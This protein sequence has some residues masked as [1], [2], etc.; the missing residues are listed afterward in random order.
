MKRESHAFGCRRNNPSTQTGDDNASSWDRGLS[1]G[2]GRWHGAVSSLPKT[3]CRYVMTALPH[4]SASGSGRSSSA[5][6][7]DSP[8]IHAAATLTERTVVP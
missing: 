5:A 8:A 2:A 6:R 4:Q 7:G 3:M 1:S